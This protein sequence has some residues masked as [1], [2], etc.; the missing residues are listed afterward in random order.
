[1]L[2]VTTADR[3]SA[4]LIWHNFIYLHTPDA[5]PDATLLFYPGL[6]LALSAI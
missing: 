6:G 1:M 3:W 2:L 5:V 4:Y